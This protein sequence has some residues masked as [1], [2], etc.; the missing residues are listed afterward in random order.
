[1]PGWCSVAPVEPGGSV[2]L[3][4][5]ERVRLRCAERHWWWWTRPMS[6][7]PQRPSTTKFAGRARN[8][9][10][11]GSCRKATHFAGA[12]IGRVIAVPELIGVR[13]CKGPYPCRTRARNWR[14]GPGSGALARTPSAVATS[15]RARTLANGT[16]QLPCT[17]GVRS[18]ATPAGP[19]RRCGR[20]RSIRCLLRVV[21]RETSAPRRSWAMRF[22]HSI[23]SPEEK[24]GVLRALSG[25]GR[26]MTPLPV[27]RRDAP[28]IEEVRFQ[29]RR[30]RKLASCRGDRAAEAAGI[31]ATSS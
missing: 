10:V 3:D 17:P 7:T 18:S 28:S 6:S 25:G 8:L 4:E 27:H 30:L 15:S 16:G 11:P 24:T 19:L 20:R 5:V 23:G 14:A 1:M 13:R 21:V 2:S 22:P 9:A 12:R 31:A 26:Q 29:I